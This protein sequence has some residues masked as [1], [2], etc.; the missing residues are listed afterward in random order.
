MN[1]RIIPPDHTIPWRVGSRVR[2]EAEHT[3]L[4]VGCGAHV[5]Y[6]EQRSTLAELLRIARWEI[7][8]C[9]LSWEEPSFEPA[10]RVLPN[11]RRFSDGPR[12]FW[13]RPQQARVRRFMPRRCW[14]PVNPPQAAALARPVR[15]DP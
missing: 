10:P 3:P 5:G 12:R 6:Q 13:P 8:H 4:E 1:G 11:D 15:F 2:L 14:C 9:A 7:W